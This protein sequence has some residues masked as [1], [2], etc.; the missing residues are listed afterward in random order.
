MIYAHFIGR[1][2]KDGA[3]VREGKNGKFITLDLATD[4][5]SGGE[6][7]T[8]WI[9]VVSNRSNLIKIAKY[10]GKGRLLNV[11]GVLGEPKIYKDKDNNPHVQ[12]MLTADVIN[13]V[14]IGKKKE[15]EDK[16]KP[17]VVEE[18]QQ[19]E[20]PFPA[21]VENVEDLPF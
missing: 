19:T 10:I 18:K 6:N 12:L 21:P 4:I 8:L 9:R 11:E 7:K 14:N 3:T 17:V 16:N 13:F 5:Y 15:D 1:A 2:G 20:N